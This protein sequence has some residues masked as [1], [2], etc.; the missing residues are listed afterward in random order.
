MAALILSLG[1][2][3]FA[4]DGV[5]IGAL[6]KIAPVIDGFD[7][8][9]KSIANVLKLNLGILD[10]VAPAFVPPLSTEEMRALGATVQSLDA[11]ALAVLQLAGLWK[12]SEGGEAV[13]EP[14]ASAPDSAP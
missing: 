3:S 14:A 2:K 9:D 10:A 7:R 1:G 6:E 13:A 8:E 5:P 12:E 4:L 11:A